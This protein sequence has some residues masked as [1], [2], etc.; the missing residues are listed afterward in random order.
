RELLAGL[1]VYTCATLTPLD[2]CVDLLIRSIAD[3]LATTQD[4][5]RPLKM[6]PDESFTFGETFYS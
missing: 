6:Q 5:E 4:S 2:A 1:A 3:L